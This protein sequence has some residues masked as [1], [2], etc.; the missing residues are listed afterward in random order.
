VGEKVKGL[1]GGNSDRQR[2]CALRSED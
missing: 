1:N 2:S